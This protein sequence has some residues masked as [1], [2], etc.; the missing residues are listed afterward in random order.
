M[1][2]SAQ[3]GA[4]PVSRG[5]NL[6]REQGHRLPKGLRPVGADLGEAGKEEMGRRGLR[7]GIGEGAGPKTQKEEGADLDWKRQEWGRGKR[8]PRDIQLGVQ[9]THTGHPVHDL[10]ECKGL[11]QL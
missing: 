11:P 10:K 2:P 3:N 5:N 6:R 4:G 9:G 7:S 8:G 1:D